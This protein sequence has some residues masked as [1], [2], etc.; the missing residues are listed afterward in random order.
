MFTLSNRLEEHLLG[1]R[2]S[3]EGFVAI[4]DITADGVPGSNSHDSDST[5]S[6]VSG[7]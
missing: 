6:R 1:F 7:S 2:I 3:L 5:A 4:N